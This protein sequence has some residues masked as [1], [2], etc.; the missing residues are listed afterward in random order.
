MDIHCIV[1]RKMGGGSAHNSAFHPH[2]SFCCVINAQVLNWQ[3]VDV[4]PSVD[5]RQSVDVRPAIRGCGHPWMSG[6]LWMWPSVDVRPSADGLD[7]RLDCNNMNDYPR[8]KMWAKEGVVESEDEEN[9]PRHNNT[10]YISDSLVW[11]LFHAPN[12]LTSIFLPLLVWLLFLCVHCVL[13]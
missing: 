11:L 1:N 2:T 3:S 12:T 6:H 9:S 5:V 10:E 13:I 8:F 7:P 4:R